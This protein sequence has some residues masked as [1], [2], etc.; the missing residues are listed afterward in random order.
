[1]LVI[2]GFYIACWLPISTWNA[3]TMIFTTIT[4]EWL[5][6]HPSAAR[7]LINIAHLAPYAN[8]ALNP[9]VYALCTGEF[10]QIVLGWCDGGGRRRRTAGATVTDERVRLPAGYI[11][12]STM[13]VARNGLAN[14]HSRT[15]LS[16][17]PQNERVVC[18]HSTR[19]ALNLPLLGDDDELLST[20]QTNNVKYGSNTQHELHASLILCESIPIQRHI[21]VSAQDVRVIA[22]ECDLTKSDCDL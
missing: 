1:V 20:Q 12:G 10:A 8:A 11:D 21:S 4:K 5:K 13:M 7:T 2:I 16:Q 9:V 6:T 22:A 18:A 15:P 14:N 19:S 3:A 17:Q